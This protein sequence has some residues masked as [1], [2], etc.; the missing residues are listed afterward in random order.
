MVVRLAKRPILRMRRRARPQ[1][2]AM[3]QEA[4]L[5]ETSR[6]HH[7]VANEA[8]A[9]T[10]GRNAALIPQAENADEATKGP[11]LSRPV[12]AKSVAT[13]RSHIPRATAPCCM[14][15]SAIADVSQPLAT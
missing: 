2:L 10:H 8:G 3:L 1:A 4:E 13:C 15:D 7:R 9:R 12:I 11:G 5:V 6:S 14:H